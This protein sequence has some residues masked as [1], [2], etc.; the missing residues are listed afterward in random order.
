MSEGNYKA[1]KKHRV[2]RGQ[3]YEFSGPGLSYY[4]TLPF[5]ILD[6]DSAEH[7]ADMIVRQLQKAYDA[8]RASKMA[9]IRRALGVHD[10][11]WGVKVG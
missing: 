9:E 5:M 1:I 4:G 2:D 3:V 11:P 8:G 7:D 6:P 10:T